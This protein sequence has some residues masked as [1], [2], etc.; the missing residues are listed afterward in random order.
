MFELKKEEIATF[1]EDGFVF[2]ENLLDDATCEAIKARYEAM[3][4]GDFETGVKPDEVNW[5]EGKS[6]PSLTRQICNGW[7]G[8]RTVASVVLREDIGRAC[9]TLGG[10]PGARIKVDNV[11]WK[12]PGTRPLGMHQDSAYLSWIDPD[13]MISCWIA[14]D[15]T[16]AQG[17]T[18]E[19]VRGSHRWAHAAP[20]GEFHGPQDYRKYMMKAAAAEGIAEP[21]IVPVVVKK[22][23]GSFHHGR[24][25][26]GSGDNKASHAR[27]S[28]V[29]H[30]LS[31]EAKFVPANIASGTGPIYGRYMPRNGDTTMD[32]NDFPILWTGQGGRSSWIDGYLKA[33]G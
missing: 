18:M 12:P 23:S 1:R 22:G 20:E 8:D 27:R 14:L 5:Q 6:D 3:F 31:S 26:H 9:A 28:L 13:E 33:Q 7:K 29:V 16:S 19:L 30:C 11:L 4:R 2:V 21:E 15:D 25:W 24:T 10:W 32:D 17:G